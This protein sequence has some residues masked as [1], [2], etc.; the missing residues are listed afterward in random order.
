MA[1]LVTPM[2]SMD[3]PD[4]EIK[5]NTSNLSMTGSEKSERSAQLKVASALA[6]ANAAIASARSM[7]S[8]RNS[9]PVTPP[10]AT[11]DKGLSPTPS[12]PNAQRQYKPMGMGSESVTGSVTSRW[13]MAS[14][15]TFT[16]R[17]RFFP[18]GVSVSASVASSSRLSASS[19]STDLDLKNNDN[20]FHVVANLLAERFE[21]KQ[22]S[23]KGHF[24][25]DTADRAYLDQM[26]PMSVRSSF[27][28]ALQY[29][30]LVCPREGSA[31]QTPL[32]LLI[33]RCQKL[34]LDKEPPNNP[35]LPPAA[36]HP[37]TVLLPNIP[38]SYSM[39]SEKSPMNGGYIP[40]TSG[41]EAD[42]TDQH[43]SSSNTDLMIPK[44]SS[45]N[46]SNLS[47]GS[48]IDKGSSK[49]RLAAQQ[50]MAELKEA[51]VLRKDSVTAE[52]ASF[53]KNHIDQL[54]AKLTELNGYGGDIQ[55]DISPF[56]N[57]TS[58]VLVEEGG[59]GLDG[60]TH[61]QSNPT[62]SRVPSLSN[63]GHK[64][65]SRTE[66]D[67]VAPADLPG[68]YTFEAQIGHT[69][70]L[71]T[72]PPGGVHRGEQFSCFMRELEKIQ[73]SA[74]IMHWREGLF[75]CMKHGICHPLLLNT[76]F[77]PL[78]ALG[79]IQ[80]RSGL[81]WRGSPGTKYEAMVAWS[82]MVQIIVFWI[83]MNC[84]IMCV[85]F[86]KWSWGQQESTSDIISLLLVNSSMLLMC[87]YTI[88]STRSS[89]RRRF[90]IPEED[91]CEGGYEDIA[92]AIFCAPCTISQMGRHTAD[93][94]TYIGVCCTETGV[95]TNVE[96]ASTQPV[97][98]H[99]SCK[100]CS[101]S[102]IA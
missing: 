100:P 37:Q 14:T 97:K 89:I 25:L 23:S 92:C 57:D 93:F 80:S 20:A 75:A 40:P 24:E 94:E 85:L 60:I 86:M 34:G 7:T 19:G 36:D 59:A 45:S 9:S 18:S 90:E 21:S 3:A 43:R 91:L 48:F 10:Q 74:P 72:V 70:F 32:Q 13:S 6:N 49:P 31:D 53:W 2:P 99:N 76:I 68:G 96:L 4:D 78:I 82:T 63:D 50:I 83:F 66:V 11:L 61:D 95:P 55:S 81:S 77:C 87:I 15:R 65:L 88:A 47:N 22:T 8:P 16:P 29:R 17:Q 1:N 56:A 84:M 39:A 41:K 54:Q 51:Q 30:L 42:K 79:Q 5:M 71:A 26:L 27:V 28:Q 35:L 46:S 62:K 101:C 67:V 69:R 102:F 52:A 44:I 58:Y 33:R 12:P 98:G 38:G 64:L 73:M